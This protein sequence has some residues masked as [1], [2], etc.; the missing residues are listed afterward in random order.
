VDWQGPNLVRCD[1]D[2]PVAVVGDV[3]GCL[4][5]L[6]ALL[7]QLG[8][9]PL[10]HLGD[11]VDRG[12]DSRGVV[13]RMIDVGAR[14]V[15][16]NHE[17]WF[18]AWASGLAPAAT[19]IPMFGEPTLHSYGVNEGQ[20][21]G[22]GSGLDFVPRAHR[23]YVCSLPVV[24]DLGVDGE[25]Y[26]LVHA[27]VPREAKLSDLLDDDD[28]PPGDPATF[29]PWFAERRRD[30]LLWVKTRPE[31]MP[32]LDRPVLFG[33]TSFPQPADLGHVVAL[34]T[35]AGRWEDA[36]LT[37]IVLPERRFVQVPAR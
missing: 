11:L 33:H 27:G 10:F 34:D 18:A 35:G 25:R 12:P 29:L 5:A 9:V 31:D 26:W 14:G 15:R 8:D 1:V 7:A 37:A 3:H 17:E 24:M 20:L 28:D 19:A 16:G 6:D 32:R 2:G 4:G 36:S 30:S 23:E 22:P 13:Q 21:P